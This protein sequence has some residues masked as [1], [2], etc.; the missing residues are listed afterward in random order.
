MKSFLRI[1]DASKECVPIEA[2]LKKNPTL[3]HYLIS[4]DPPRLDLG[5]PRALQEY[6]NTILKIK[7]GLQLT[8]S[9]DFLIPSVCL[10][11]IF[12]EA[13]LKKSLRVLEI[14]IGASA[15]M[16]MITARNFNCNVVGTETNLEAIDIANR[17]IIQN[18][19][20]DKVKVIDSKGQILEGLPPS[21]GSFDLIFSYPPQYSYLEGEKFTTHQRGFRGVV[22]ELGWGAKG[23]SFASR[24]IQEASHTLFLKKSG[25]LALLI[26]NENLLQ[27]VLTSMESYG[28]HY[29][30]I[31]IH[32]GTR[33]RFIAIGEK[34]D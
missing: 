16:G 31:K 34:H 30:S 11:L 23:T 33:Q 24:L 9:E 2:A 4:N 29:N 28:F 21:L 17:N 5:S 8:L 27:E 14:G 12:L 26:L 13:I 22:S 10:R 18:D 1:I 6:N 3:K 19:L 7:T 25:K 32:A 15:V 20:S